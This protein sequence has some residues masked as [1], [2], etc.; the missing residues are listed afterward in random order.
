MIPPHDVSKDLQSPGK[1]RDKTMRFCHS[2][3]RGGIICQ[4]NY[5]HCLNAGPCKPASLPARGSR[6]DLCSLGRYTACETTESIPIW[7]N[8]PVSNTVLF[9]HPKGAFH[10]QEEAKSGHCLSGLCGTLNTKPIYWVNSKFKLDSVPYKFSEL[11][12]D[13]AKYK[14]DGVGPVDTRPFAKQ[15]Q[16]NYNNIRDM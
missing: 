5:K 7:G 14:L 4:G 2:S 11:K 9:L 12:D 6:Q 15:Q 16:K 8:H 3:Q 13:Q 10:F 1:D